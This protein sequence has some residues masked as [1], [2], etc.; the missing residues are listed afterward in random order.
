MEQTMTNLISEYGEYGDYGDIQVPA[1]LEP[2]YFTTDRRGRRQRHELCG[3]MGSNHEP[4]QRIMDGM[5]S[6]A[7][8]GL[9]K[10]LYN[11]HNYHLVAF[12]RLPEDSWSCW[13]WEDR[14]SS[15]IACSSRSLLM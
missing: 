13:Q 3:S 12:Y 2:G 15:A 6:S 14:R 5:L 4:H 11:R 1:I 9:M 10:V 7:A 8:Q